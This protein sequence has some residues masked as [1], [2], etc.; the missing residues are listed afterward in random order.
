MTLNK[1]PKGMK[2]KQEV[3]LP[4]K[5]SGKK[6]DPHMAGKKSGQGRALVARK[7]EEPQQAGAPMLHPE[8]SA[9]CVGGKIV[10]VSGKTKEQMEDEAIKALPELTGVKSFY[11]S[12][13][14]LNQ[15]ATAL[16]FP[17]ISDEDAILRASAAISE[18]AP[19]NATEAML[20]TQMIATHE[21]VCMFIM[22]A[23]LKD[24]TPFGV[25]SNT[26][27]ANRL[28]RA[29]MEQV[30]LMQKLKGHTSQQKVTVEHVHIH[31]GGQAIVGAVAGSPAGRGRGKNHDEQ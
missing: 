12:D 26:D 16:S 4:G 17:K 15:V 10:F 2:T 1:G 28:M 27:R 5:I 8:G 20:A 18:H 14:L 21:A 24:Q 6:R 9:R 19:R 31:A 25:D 23:T 13:R 3:L 30:E 29:F 22:R 11:A 7:T